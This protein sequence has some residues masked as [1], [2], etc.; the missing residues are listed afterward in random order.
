MMLQHLWR[1]IATM[2]SK[3]ARRN[4]KMFFNNDWFCS[5]SAT[6]RWTDVCE[7]YLFSHF[8]KLDPPCC[9]GKKDWHGVDKKE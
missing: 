8:Q 7:M 3:F 6:W 1:K 5:R 4:M 2:T 9:S